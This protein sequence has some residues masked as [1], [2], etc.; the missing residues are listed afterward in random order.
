MPNSLMPDRLPDV[1]HEQANALLS[2]SRDLLAV[3][4][5]QGDFLFVNDSFGR[6]LGYS[7]DDLIGK[8]L[9]WLHP[10]AEVKSISE[11]FAA[12]VTQDGATATCRC[13]LR[14]KSGQWRWFDVVAVNRLQ[15]P[16]VQGIL[17]SY[18]DITEFERMEAQRMVL[19]NV[20]HALNETS[21]LDDLLHQIHGALKKVVYA[22]NFFVAL[23]D[24]QTEMFHFPFF[25]DQFDPPPPPQKVAR[26]CMAYIFRSGKSCLIPQNEFDRLAA[27][28]EVELVGSPS[29]SWLGV[30]LKTPTATIG[31]LVVQHY[32]NE[33]AYDIR[34]LEFLG[35]VGGQIAVAIERRR[36][37]DALR[38][39]EE[40]F[41][42]LFSYNPLPTWVIDNETRRFLE[43]ND[44]AIRQYGYS[45]NE[46]KCMTAFDLR[47]EEERARYLDLMKQM[48]NDGL[49][50]GNWK[51]RKKDGKIIQVEIISHELEYAGRRVRL[52]VAQD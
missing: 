36:S 17:L 44:A 22:E 50:Q 28:G 2:L 20:V 40:M 30:P 41:R 47:P 4:S 27:E 9:S 5:A 46:F 34:D 29:P 19:S 23:H 12:L 8:P 31:V 39:N 32:Q 16:N 35:S 48:P 6:V 52:V 21:N 33:N 13:S 15:D 43:V 24:P 49:Y 51:H 25:V 18:Q 3:V 10:S 11:K 45:L 1:S 37:E 38:K 26:T 14:S 7:P 42:L